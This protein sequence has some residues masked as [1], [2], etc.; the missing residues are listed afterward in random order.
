MEPTSD[1]RS[2]KCS[3]MSPELDSCAGRL[4][5]VCAVADGLEL[6]PVGIE[7]VGRVTVLPVLRELARFVEND[8]PA[9]TSPLVCVPDD[10]SAGDE[11]TNV[12]KARVSA[13]VRSRFVRLIEEQLR[14]ASAVGSV[15]EWISGLPLEPL[16]K[17]EDGHEL[18]VV[19]LGRFEIRHSE[20]DVIDESGSRQR[21]LPVVAQA[22]GHASYEPA[23]PSMMARR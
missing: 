1:C 7:P 14:A 23:S 5:L 2:P 8:G 12:M 3:G 18:V 20:A 13:R 17:P 11:E 15:V 6:E 21:L 22:W 10:R 9:G 19:L 16:P 4:G